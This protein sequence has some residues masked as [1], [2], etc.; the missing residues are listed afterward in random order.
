MLGQVLVHQCGPDFI[1]WHPEWRL[2]LLSYAPKALH[3]VLALCH[4]GLLLVLLE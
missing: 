2:A 4:Y 1:P 3:H